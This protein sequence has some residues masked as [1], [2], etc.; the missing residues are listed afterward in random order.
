MNNTEKINELRNI[1]SSK[2]KPLIQKQI[3]IFGL[4]F[5][6][7][8]GDSLITMGE[9]QL[10]NELGAKIIYMR[11]VMDSSTPLPTLPRDCTILLQGGGDFGDIWRGIQEARINIIS[12][13]QE[14]RIIIF[15][16]TVEYLDKSLMT[17]DALKLNNATDL[18]ICARDSTSYRILIDNFKNNILLVPDMAF[19]IKQSS[20]KKY[21]N[22]KISTKNLFLK[23]TDKELNKHISIPSSTDEDISDWPIIDNNLNSIKWNLNALGYTGACSKRKLH[24]MGSLIQWISLKAIVHLGYRQIT[25]IGVEFLTSYNKIRVTRLHAGILAILLGKPVEII[26]NSYHKNL[27]FYNT[28]LKD[29]SNVSFI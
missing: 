8:I 23:R 26:D 2:L 21:M 18:Y 15:P 17:Q 22:K 11:Q 19:F 5:H 29:V 13:Y 16:Q 28:W 3:A 24:F 14:N 9:L 7:N 6:G 25:K 10:L 20:L 27:N 12:K 1:I 4:P